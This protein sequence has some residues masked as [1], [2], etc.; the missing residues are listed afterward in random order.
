MMVWFRRLLMENDLPEVDTASRTVCGVVSV[1]LVS[2]WAAK[3]SGTDLRGKMYER[4]R[5]ALSSSS[6]LGISVQP[7]GRNIPWEG[8][9]KLKRCFMYI[10][11]KWWGGVSTRPASFH[12]VWVKKK[13][14]S[15]AKV[16]ISSVYLC[17][18]WWYFPIHVTV[19]EFHRDNEFHFRI[20]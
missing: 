12:L 9:S 14:N 18:L 6:L 7:V 16:E 13:R 4:R 10:C 3:L 20:L 15:S 5:Q 2:Q 8:K 19:V 1:Q 11:G 17:R